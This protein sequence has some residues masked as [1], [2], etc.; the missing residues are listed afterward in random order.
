MGNSLFRSEDKRTRCQLGFWKQQIK[1]FK[2]LVGY[3]VLENE[4][5]NTKAYV[6]LTHSW[7]SRP[8][9]AMYFRVSRPA[10]FLRYSLAPGTRPRCPNQHPHSFAQP[11]FLRKISPT[12]FSLV[13]LGIIC[14]SYPK[15]GFRAWHQI[16]FLSFKLLMNIAAAC[17]LVVDF[18]WAGLQALVLP[19]VAL[20]SPPPAFGLQ[21]NALW[22]YTARCNPEKTR[23][24]SLHWSS[25][26]PRDR[27]WMHCCKV[28][29]KMF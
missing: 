21:P 26:A 17:F 9:M 6:V 20:A 2:V 12:H 16:W 5:E 7:W 29:L 8:M 22:L 27:S 13:R 3:M 1:T 14:T 4:N 23:I 24:W 15:L 10:C 28:F 18:L 25:D 19:W 11:R